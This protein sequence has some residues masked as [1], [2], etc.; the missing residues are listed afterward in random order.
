MSDLKIIEIANY[1]VSNKA[2]VMDTANYFNISKS[3]L[4]KVI[5]NKLVGID[6]DLYS[7]VKKV[8]IHNQLKGKIK[9]G[10]ISKRTVTWTKEDAY[11]LAKLML[12][13][14][15]TFEE[16][17]QHTL[18]PIS[19]LSDILKNG[20]DDEIIKNSLS[21]LYEYN[22]TIGKSKKSCV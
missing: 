8:Q 2:S 16:L 1:I 12:A 19:T 9:G 18:I 15:M 13:E 3:T 17:S 14:K 21:S 11:R 6:I 5:N 20:I 22:K 7:L 10:Q 4:Q